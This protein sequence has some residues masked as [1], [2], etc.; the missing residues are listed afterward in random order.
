MR[1]TSRCGAQW[2]ASE[3]GGLSRMH[4]EELFSRWAARDGLGQ[5]DHRRPAGA[6][7]VRWA[8][9][10][11]CRRPAPMHSPPRPRPD[12]PCR[13][14]TRR[15]PYPQHPAP[16]TLQAQ[17]APLRFFAR[18]VLALDAVGGASAAR[19][20]GAL[21]DVSRLWDD[22][23]ATASLTPLPP[24][25][26]PASPR[27]V[28]GRLCPSRARAQRA[29]RRRHARTPDLHTAA[30]PDHRISPRARP[31]LARAAPS[32]CTAASA[33]RRPRSTGRTTFSGAHGARA[34]GGNEGM[35]GWGI[36]GWG[37]WGDAP[38]HCPPAPPT[39]FAHAAGASPC[40]ASTRARGPRRTQ[41]RPRPRSW[42]LGA[43]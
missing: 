20:A 19:M 2:H 7:P 26:L 33:A 9:S 3:G 40:A 4:G 8:G 29:A 38:L 17:L 34:G 12:T 35:R 27:P 18:P 24:P 15:A 1:G 22:R 25:H 5:D 14:Q 39:A 37:D 31:L 16:L 11:H 30:P 32:R 41:Q 43:W 42:P 10:R 21:A 23:G 36:K 13:P 6:R 28:G